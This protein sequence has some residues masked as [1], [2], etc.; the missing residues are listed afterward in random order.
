MKTSRN[1]YLALHPIHC[2]ICNALIDRQ[3]TAFEWD[4]GTVELS[5][6][7]EKIRGSI[8]VEGHCLKAQAVYRIYAYPI[9]C[10]HPQVGQTNT[11]EA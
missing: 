11:N 1:A 2:I 4:R 7:C 8:E 9:C 10:S 6:V 5:Y 3:I